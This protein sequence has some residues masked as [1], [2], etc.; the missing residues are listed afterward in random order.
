[1]SCFSSMASLCFHLKAVS[2]FDYM[3]MQESLFWCACVYVCL[4]V[5]VYVCVYVCLCLLLIPEWTQLLEPTQWEEREGKPFL[6]PFRGNS[7]ASDKSSN[8]LAFFSWQRKVGEQMRTLK[9]SLA[10]SALSFPISWFYH[11]SQ[12]GWLDPILQRT[13]N[14]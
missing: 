10:M 2:C 8:L 12:W 13:V 11:F 9:A 14:H 6:L 4:C 7:K 3:T 5:C 1:M